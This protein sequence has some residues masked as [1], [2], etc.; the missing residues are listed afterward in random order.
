MLTFL[1]AL[2]ALFLF[3]TTT[4]VDGD[5]NFLPDSSAEPTTFVI[6]RHAEKADNSTDPDLS[7]AGYDRAGRLAAVLQYMNIDGLHATPFKRTRQTLSVIAENKG[8]DILEYDPKN[9]NSLLDTLKGEFGKTHVI[10]GHSNTAPHIVNY[11]SGNRVYTDL[12]DH[13]YDHLWIVHC[14]PDGSSKTVLLH[15]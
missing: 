2:T 9:P 11:L 5:V 6:V 3:F 7:Q 13:I 14:Y 1:S 15:Y 10:A 4:Q 8:I 12:E